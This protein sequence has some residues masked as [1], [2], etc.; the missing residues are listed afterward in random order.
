MITREN[1]LDQIKK[2][3]KNL[4]DTIIKIWNSEIIAGREER[5]SAPIELSARKMA[6]KIIIESHHKNLGIA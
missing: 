5:Y 2:E 4:H 1:E 3:N 6:I